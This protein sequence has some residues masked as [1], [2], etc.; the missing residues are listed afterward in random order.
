MGFF[1][2]LFSMLISRVDCESE[3]QFQSVMHLKLTLEILSFFGSMPFR[4]NRLTQ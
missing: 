4:K 2:A 3:S 1:A